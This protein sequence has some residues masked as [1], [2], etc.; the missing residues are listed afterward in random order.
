MAKQIVVQ[1]VVSGPGGDNAVTFVLW[2]AVAAGREVPIAG[3]VSAWAGASTAENTA[4]AAGQVIEESYQIQYPVAMTKAQ[5]QTD[6]LS[7]FTA[8]QAQITAR[9]NPNVYFGVYYDPAATGWSA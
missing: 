4:I 9:V 7:R 6:L 8:R 1:R 5:I 3:G 2:L